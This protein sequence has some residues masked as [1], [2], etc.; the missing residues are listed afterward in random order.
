MYFVLKQMF[1]LTGNKILS[2]WNSF[3]MPLKMKAQVFRT[4]TTCFPWVWHLLWITS[5]FC[6]ECLN[7]Q[8]ISVS[9]DNSN[10]L[11]YRHIHW[12]QAKRQEP[13]P[14]P[15]PGADLPSVPWQPLLPP[16][17][18]LHPPSALLCCSGQFSEEKPSWL[19]LEEAGGNERDCRGMAV[20]NSKMS[21]G[22]MLI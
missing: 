16:K 21:K 7:H 6:K 17:W 2:F 5:Q 13:P 22:E 20:F 19:W 15:H 8:D 10:T 1:H 14:V 11:L 4:G 12:A 9:L 3:G 18:N